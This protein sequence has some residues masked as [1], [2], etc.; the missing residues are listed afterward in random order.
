MQGFGLTGRLRVLICWAQGMIQ[1]FFEYKMLIKS[2]FPS[3]TLLGKKR[4]REEISRS[5][6]ELKR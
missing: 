3:I 4:L 1:K 5:V 6:G 2:K